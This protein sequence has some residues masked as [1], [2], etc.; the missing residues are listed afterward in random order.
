VDEEDRRWK[1]LEAISFP[2]PPFLLLLDEYRGRFECLS[3]SSHTLSKPDVGS[4]V[5]HIAGVVVVMIHI[6]DL[7]PL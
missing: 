7:D 4:G 5:F 1:S 3:S 6:E 2:S